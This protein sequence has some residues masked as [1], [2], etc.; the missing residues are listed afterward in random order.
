MTVSKNEYENECVKMNVGGAKGN[1]INAVYILL[2]E[3]C[4]FACRAS[5][6]DLW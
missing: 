4:E 3:D 2:C 6:M 1:I 5:I